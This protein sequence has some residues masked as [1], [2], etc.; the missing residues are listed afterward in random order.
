MLW[1]GAARGSTTVD[2]IRATKVTAAYLF[3]LTRLIDWPEGTFTSAD[4]S[5]RIA[6]VGPDSRGLADYFRDNVPVREFAGHPLN[7]Q[8]VQSCSSVEELA[9]NHI[10]FFTNPQENCLGRMHALSLVGGIL[11]AGNSPRFCRSGGMV[12]FV[13][14]DGRIRIEVNLEVLRNANLKL[15]AEFLQHAKTVTSRTREEE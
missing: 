9:R 13:L 7:V 6:F 2:Q 8:V 5:L 10:V 14:A 11:T 4:D 15:S 12:S 3:H 1:T